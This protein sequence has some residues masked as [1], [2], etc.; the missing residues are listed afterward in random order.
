MW[1][2]SQSHFTYRAAKY[3]DD[4]DDDQAVFDWRKSNPVSIGHDVWIGHGAIILPGVNIG[5]GAV[6]AAGAVVTKNVPDYT[7]VTNIP[8]KP[9]K[10]RFSED[11]SKQLIKIAWWDWSHEK[12]RDALDDFRKKTIEE[13][14]EKYKITNQ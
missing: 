8:A 2:A 1:R 4:A 6:V 11:I 7:I 10:L 9:L 12:L 14:V 5:H 13:F 3:W